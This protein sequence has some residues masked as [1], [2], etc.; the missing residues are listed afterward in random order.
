MSS[1]A[2]DHRKDSPSLSRVLVAT[3][4][5]LNVP[6]EAI[7]TQLP[8]ELTFPR[9]VW[10]MPLEGATIN[11]A[12]RNPIVERRMLPKVFFTIQAGNRSG[13]EST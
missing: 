7:W 5:S 9:Q 10:A 4:E 1:T 2:R 6:D 3:V 11:G 13:V 8:A 12:I